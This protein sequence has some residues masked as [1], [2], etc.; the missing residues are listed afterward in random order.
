MLDSTEPTCFLFLQAVSEQRLIYG[1][2]LLP[3][4]LHIRD[5]FTQ[6]CVTINLYTYTKLL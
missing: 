5:I 4:H 2:K 1:G 3:D 6:V